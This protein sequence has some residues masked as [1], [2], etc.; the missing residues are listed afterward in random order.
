M[1]TTKNDKR[2]LGKKI[3][4]RALLNIPEKQPSKR[5]ILH[6]YPEIIRH[7]QRNGSS[8]IMITERC[9]VFFNDKGSSLGSIRL[10]DLDW[11]ENS[12]KEESLQLQQA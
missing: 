11:L 10:S 5:E 7:Y 9:I 12:L 8:S 1:E 4:S 3:I 2:S 6:H